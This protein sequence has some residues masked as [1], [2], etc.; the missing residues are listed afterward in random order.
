MQPAGLVG[1]RESPTTRTPPHVAKPPTAF[2]YRMRNAREASDQTILQAGVLTTFS[3]ARRKY[4]R[5]A[6][7]LLLTDLSRSHPEPFASRTVSVSYSERPLGTQI[8]APVY[9][10]KEFARTGRTT[11]DH[12]LLSAPPC[13]GTYLIGASPTSGYPFALAFPRIT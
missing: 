11:G 2:R 7:Q 4:G 8:L 13:P 5:H 10:F 9:L 1:L 6:V 3:S 12:G